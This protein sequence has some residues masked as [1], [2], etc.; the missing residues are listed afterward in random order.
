MRVA[1]WS[2]LFLFQKNVGK[3]AEG[4]RIGEDKVEVFV[5]VENLPG[6]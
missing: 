2:P 3:R 1:G 5:G 6:E 4:I